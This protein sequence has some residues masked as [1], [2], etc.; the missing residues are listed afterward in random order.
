MW[1]GPPPVARPPR[2]V[3]RPASSSRKALI[4]PGDDSVT[5]YSVRR[6]GES[7]T[8]DGSATA[9]DQLSTVSA[10]GA[11]ATPA[12]PIPPPPDP[13]EEPR[14]ARSVAAAPVPVGGVPAE[15]P[16]D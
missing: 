5:A 10:P 15:V 16:A 11:G 9:G 3:G 6:S 1:H 2:S 13:V 8:Q 4:R 12:T 14:Y 7:S